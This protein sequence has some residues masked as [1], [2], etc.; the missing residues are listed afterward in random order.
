MDWN[1]N[2]S[3]PY[4]LYNTARYVI[5]IPLLFL[6][7][8]IGIKASESH[9]NTLVHVQFLLLSI[10]AWYFCGRIAHLYADRRSNKYSEEIVFIFYTIFLFTIVESAIL[11]FLQ[12]YNSHFIA[13]FLL[14]FFLLLVTGKYI[15]RKYIHFVISRGRLYEKL[16]IVGFTSAAHDFYDTINKYYY[17]GYKC[18]GI[19]ND[20]PVLQEAHLYEGPV[21][22]LS[23]VLGEKNIDEV[24]IALPNSQDQQIKHCM[25]ICDTYGKR[26]RLIPD[27]YQYASSTARVNHIGLI[28]VIDLRSLPLDKWENRL[29]KRTFDLIFSGLF[30]LLCGIWLFPL[31]AL[32]VKL[33][34]KGPVFF[35]QERWGFNNNK[36]TCYK[37]RTMKAGSPETDGN[38]QFLQAVKNDPRVTRVG[39]Y[40]RKTNLD[41]LP[42][43]LNVLQGSMS[44]IGP[45]PHATPMNLAS[46]FTVD[47]Y[48]LR[49]SVKPGISGWAQV[50]GSRGET[51]SEGAMQRRVNLDLYYIHRWTFWLD[52]Q[53]ILQT[54][55]NIIRGDQNAY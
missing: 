24:I 34:S 53:I 47:N 44:V 10:V 22:K 8:F 28:P 16:L 32:L 43:F 31:I 48:L 23:Q 14:A 3:S 52:I 41:E 21:D 42:Q 30:F 33:S 19:L 46:M 54:V 40:L 2:M 55:I 39:A 36:I 11:F 35:K 17:Y 13:V 49:H 1:K 50:N 37:F 20:E 12:N 27:F 38:G 4:H 45:R 6:A 7:Y 26:V 29:L 51:S 15:L 25:Q 9:L 18:V 5:D